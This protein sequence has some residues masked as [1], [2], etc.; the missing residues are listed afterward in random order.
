L[1]KQEELKSLSQQLRVKNEKLAEEA[2][3]ENIQSILAKVKTEL[4]KIQL[5]TSETAIN[6]AVEASRTFAIQ[7]FTETFRHL[8][9]L[10]AYTTSYQSLLVHS[11][12]LSFGVETV[13]F[14]T[15]RFVVE[16]VKKEIET[17]GSELQEENIKQLKEVCDVELIKVQRLLEKEADNFWFGFSFRWYAQRIC[18]E[19][20][21]SRIPEKSLRVKVIDHF[22]E[23]ELGYLMSR[24][25]SW[26]N[27]LLY[28]FCVIILFAVL[29]T[30]SSRFRPGVIRQLTLHK[31]T[32]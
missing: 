30:I 27:W 23:Q 14:L 3:N 21:A 25:T 19:R 18:D 13:C 10:T 8:N 16:I 22:I 29:G 9:Y 26:Q 28:S 12:I 24:I 4:K 31:D 15:K 11:I 6:N 5:P 7:Q 17:I 2:M 20:L 1:N 32:T